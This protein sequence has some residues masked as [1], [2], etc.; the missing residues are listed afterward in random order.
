ML[1]NMKMLSALAGLMKNR[2]KIEEAGVRIREK[3]ARTRVQGQAG[4]GAARATVSGA[5]TL[6]EVELS[7][8]LVNGM[9]AD[10]KTRKL[11]GD[12]ICEAVNAA[13]REAQLKMKAAVDEEAKGLGFEN[14]LP[15][16]FGGLLG[17][18]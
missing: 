16:V 12:L 15:D 2:D 7:P 9:A 18:K 11:A 6:L 10:E 14:G 4:G 13:I 17:Q 1:D 5:M 8:A 3:L